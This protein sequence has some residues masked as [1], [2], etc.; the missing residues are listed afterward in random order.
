MNGFCGTAKWDVLLD[1]CL[2]LIQENR[3]IFWNTAGYGIGKLDGIQSDVQFYGNIQTQCE[4]HPVHVGTFL[5]KEKIHYFL[6]GGWNAWSNRLTA[7]DYLSTS[8]GGLYISRCVLQV[9]LCVPKA[10]KFD[11]IQYILRTAYTYAESNIC[12]AVCRPYCFY[13]VRAPPPCNLSA[14][15]D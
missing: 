14:K 8:P 15:T 9:T 6:K 2:V 11:K 5:R 1:L 12:V 4:S 7:N 10:T 3:F 13:L